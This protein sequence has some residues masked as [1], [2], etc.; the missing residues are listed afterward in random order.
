MEKMEGAKPL[1]E[2]DFPRW[3][4]PDIYD[5]VTHIALLVIIEEYFPI[6][7]YY[8]VPLRV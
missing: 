6:C 5:C 8:I 4:R 7:Q 3:T 2:C 1:L